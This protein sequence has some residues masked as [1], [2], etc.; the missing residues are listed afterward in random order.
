MFSFIGLHQLAHG[1]PKLQWL[2]ESS[3]LVAFAQC[4]VLNVCH[5]FK[6]FKS[7]HYVHFLQTVSLI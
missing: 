6:A 1:V 5:L 7:R 4:L 3:F 2:K